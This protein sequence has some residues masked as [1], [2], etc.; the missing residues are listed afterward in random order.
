MYLNVIT[1]Y[2]RPVRY[3]IGRLHDVGNQSIGQY[4]SVHKDSF[5]NQPTNRRLEEMVAVDWRKMKKFKDSQLG[6]HGHMHTGSQSI[7]SIGVQFVEVRVC[8][9]HS[10]EVCK[11]KVMHSSNTRPGGFDFTSKMH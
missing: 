8:A 9:R 10:S 1:D 7:L 6:H 11:E 5:S 3:H 2:V 4:L